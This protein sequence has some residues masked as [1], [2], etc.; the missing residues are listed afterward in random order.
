MDISILQIETFDLAAASIVVDVHEKIQI[1]REEALPG[2]P[3]EYD[4]VFA[5]GAVHIGWYNWTTLAEEL[6]VMPPPKIPRKLDI[7]SFGRLHTMRWVPNDLSDRLEKRH[8]E[9]D[10]HFV[11]LN[12]KVSYALFFQRCSLTRGFK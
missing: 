7:G 5:N 3:M 9:V 8:L 11:G 2:C 4:F 12:F 6:A 1:S 10:I